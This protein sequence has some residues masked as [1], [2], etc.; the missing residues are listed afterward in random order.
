MLIHR[1]QFDAACDA[2]GA[3]LKFDQP[4]DAVLRRYFREHPRLGSTDKAFVGDAVYGLLRRKRLLDQLISEPTPRRL[5]LAYLG[6]VA[7]ST[8]RELAAAV[9]SEDL[10][11][12]GDIKAQ[13]P[14]AHSL[15]VQADLPDWLVEKLRQQMAD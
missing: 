10:R 2:L 11:Y 8:A 4:A 12:F 15:G 5:L 6:R 9:T 14:A 13:E 7:G 1:S 3:V